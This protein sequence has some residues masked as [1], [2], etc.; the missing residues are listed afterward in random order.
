MN[1]IALGLLFAGSILLSACSGDDPKQPIIPDGASGGS[2]TLLKPIYAPGDGEIPLPNDLLFNGTQDLTLNIPVDDPNDYSDP[3]VALS[4][5]D[6][7]SP[8]APFVVSFRDD[9]A[10][11]GKSEALDLDPNTIVPGQTVRLFKVNVLRSEVM[12]GVIAPTGPV[13][14]VAMELQP[15]VDYVATYSAPLTV[16]IVPLKPFEP[17]ASY[18]VVLTNGIKDQNGN[19][20]IPD[21]QYAVAKTESPLSGVTAALEPV[22]Q[23]VNAMENAAVAFDQNLSKDEI[24][25]SFQFT[26]QSISNSLMA[27][28]QV[29][30]DPA[31]AP[32]TS[33]SSLM[34]DTTPFTGI[35]A[36]DLYKGQ[37]TINYM[38]GTPANN[39]LDVVSKFWTAASMVPDGQGG[40]MPNPMAGGFLTYANPL[41]EITAQE[42]VPLLVSMPKASLGC[43]K[44]ANGYPVVIFQHGITSNRTV[45]LGIA[46]TMA[47]PPL[48]TAV[49][50]M[51]MPLHGID[52]NNPVHLGLMQAT[53]GQIGLFEGYG[54]GVHERTF[55]VDLINNSTGAPGP[56][57]VPDSSGAHMVNLKNL[58][59][60]RDNLREAIFDLLQL[61][62]AVPAMD[63]DGDSQPD[64]DANKITFM[65]HSLGG[66]I[67]GSFLAY[68]D[69]IQAGILANPAGGLAKMFNA[70]LTFGPTLEAG[71]AA[72][73]IQPNTPDYEA[74]LFAAQT[75]VDSGD[76]LNVMDILL[77]K[78]TPVFMIQVNNDTVVPNAVAGAPLSGTVPYARLLGLTPVTPTQAGPFAGTHL[79]S[80]FKSG[81]HST[82]LTPN[83]A[84][85]NPTFLDV[86]TEMQTEIAGWVGS[87]GQSVT[88][89]DP[90]L[91]MAPTK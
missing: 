89:G 59:V 84:E 21:G 41:P 6:G 33:F 60:G 66:I 52:E 15:G 53:G 58:L 67:G 86:Y 37:I 26:I 42:T 22:R 74:F 38:L 76:P 40:M 72:V 65:G 44:P 81:L 24:V 29:Y 19:R 46:D 49:V 25:L 83:D 47:A 61:A 90:S 71:L 73:G 39:P 43:T 55:G 77:A 17:Q 50:A 36:A 11:A 30:I 1:K 87:L 62:K 18:M 63:V 80:V 8:V 12:P 54:S 23:L 2:T 14:S 4:G 91:L 48:C 5:L 34:T 31:P 16:A 27:A 56:D 35:G 13:T 32:S 51:D 28:K 79:W 70:S 9:S 45:M 7:W 10:A 82:V 69:N 68:A 64:F 88:V 75:V 20:V 57:G 85:G 3:K 78:Q